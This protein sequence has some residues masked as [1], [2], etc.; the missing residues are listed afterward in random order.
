M[1]QIKKTLLRSYGNG[2]KLRFDINMGSVGWGEHFSCCGRSSVF[3][4]DPHLAAESN[5]CTTR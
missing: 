1:K 3:Q 2:R 5:L 4:G